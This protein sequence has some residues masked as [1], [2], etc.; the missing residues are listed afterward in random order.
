MTEPT[1]P[2]GALVGLMVLGTGAVDT[3]DGIVRSIED[4]GEPERRWRVRRRGDL[5]RVEDEDGNPESIVGESY[6]WTSFDN[7]Q[8]VYTALS[9]EGHGHHHAPIGGI[10]VGGH[11]PSFERW[12]GTDFTRP[13]GPVQATT[14]LGR[15]AW[16]VEL[17]PPSHKP[18]PLQLTVD[19]ATG[20]IMRRTNE[21]FGTIQEW[22][23]VDLEADLADELFVWRGSA[24]NSEELHAQRRAEHERLMAE[25]AEWLAAHGFVDLPLTARGRLNLHESDDETGSVY[26][27]VNY[28]DA[29]GTL[30][31][32]AASSEPWEQADEVRA[33]H[34]YRWSDDQWDWFYGTEQEASDA[35]LAALRAALSRT[36]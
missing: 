23:S 36:T 7:E 5:R 18:H 10:D 12:E 24:I 30:I 35:E 20:L 34:K 8:V 3:I 2:F 6:G 26:A 19:A 21:A 31:R 32:R 9:Q 29:F 15:P 28:F 25:H 14:F 33:K 4:E 13:T 17:A 27:S 22:V 1:I 11:R 16:F